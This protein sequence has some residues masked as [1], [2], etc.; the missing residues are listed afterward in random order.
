MQIR[1]YFQVCISSQNQIIPVDTMHSESE[2]EDAHGQLEVV[3]GLI[4]IIV[5][6]IKK[7]RNKSKT[8]D[9]STVQIKNRESTFSDCYQGRTSMNRDSTYKLIS[10]LQ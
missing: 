7:Q 4:Q 1:K 5:I 10:D 3:Y 2:K 9:C 6:T 8:S